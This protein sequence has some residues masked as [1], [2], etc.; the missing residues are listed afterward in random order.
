MLRDKL[1]HFFIFLFVLLSC[2]HGFAF[3]KITMSVINS[4][5]YYTADAL[6]GEK[7]GVAI[8]LTSEAWKAVNVD[9]TFEFIPMARAVWSVIEHHHAAM[10]GT[11]QWFAKEN[12]AHLIEAIDL[13]KIRF[14]FFYKKSK[15]PDGFAYEALHELK[16]FTVGNVRGSSTLPYLQAAGLNLELVGEVEQNFKKLYTGRIDLAVG[17]DLSG[18]AILQK[19]YPDA[20]QEFA[21]IEKSFFSAL[22]SAIFPKKQTRLIQK[23]RNGLGKL[24]E[25]GTYQKIIEEYYGK[26]QALEDIVPN[27]LLYK[28]DPNR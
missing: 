28:F 26:G 24:V 6:P 2:S 11:P 4:P 5:P 21:T 13:L 10:L 23:F 22:I 1:Y 15:F 9:V 8:D 3:E 19:L 14:L 12:K 7:R 27:S 17:V 16:K 25:D 18:W 20:R